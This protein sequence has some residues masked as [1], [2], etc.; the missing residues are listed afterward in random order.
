MATAYTTPIPSPAGLPS[1]LT[2]RV[3]VMRHDG[4][5]LT[6]EERAAAEAVYPPAP[7]AE[8]LPAAKPRGAAKASARAPK[9]AAPAAKAR[10]RAAA[11][12]P[13]AR[14]RGAR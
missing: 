4:G 12:R 11:K 13:A 7:E 1:T 8:M 6:A 2:V 5:T 9:P 10:K 14:P 3:V